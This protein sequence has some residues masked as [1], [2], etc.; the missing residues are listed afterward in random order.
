MG[1]DKKTK[2][3]PSKIIV[4]GP[5]FEYRKE[6]ARPETKTFAKKAAKKKK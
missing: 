2:V 6:L 5:K 4:K 3:D 1:E